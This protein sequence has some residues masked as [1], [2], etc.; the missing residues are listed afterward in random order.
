MKAKSTTFRSKVF[1]WAHELVK[2]TGKSIAVC[3]A[4]A[5]SIYRLKKRMSTDTVKIAFEKVDGTLRIAFAT[6]NNITYDSKNT[7]QKD[8]KTVAYFDTVANAFRSFRIEN[9]IT[10]Y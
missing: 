1:N 5:W 8:F 2:S 7:K 4:K 6:L 3:L 9:F 10:A